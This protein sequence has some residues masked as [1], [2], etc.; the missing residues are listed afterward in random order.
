M[1][2]EHKIYIS[3][4]SACSSK[5]SGNRVLLSMNISPNDIVGSVRIS[6][7]KNNTEHEVIEAS[8]ILKET[9]YNLID[10]LR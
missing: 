7:S 9:Y 1:L 3:T 10:K 6:F 8:K 2:E 5:K 4:G